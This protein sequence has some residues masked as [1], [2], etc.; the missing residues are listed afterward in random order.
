MEG[1]V[2]KSRQQSDTIK[3]LKEMVMQS[4]EKV[5]NLENKIG[6]LEN[7]VSNL[8]EI[9]DTIASANANDASQSGQADGPEE[10][11]NGTKIS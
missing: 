2:E 8:R 4:K 7:T 11:A 9:V 1:V 10:A 5:T 3:E 6:A